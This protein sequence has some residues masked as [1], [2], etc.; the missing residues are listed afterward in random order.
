M[1][2]VPQAGFERALRRAG[3][4][5]RGGNL[6][7]V[8]WSTATD[9]EM[10]GNV[11]WAGESMGIFVVDWT[12]SRTVEL[13]ALARKDVIVCSA[14]LD[15]DGAQTEFTIGERRFAAKSSDMTVVFVPHHESFR[16]ATSV[17]R[18]LKA[19]TVVVDV[20]SVMKAHG[21]PASG[22]PKWLLR[23]IQA[24]RI[25][26]ETLP[27]RH[28]GAVAR[29]VA[30]RRAMYP[31]LATLYYEGKTFELVSAL[32]G[33]L[34][35]H[36]AVQAGDGGFDPR[37]G[38]RLA[39]VKQVIDQAPHRILDVDALACIAAMN[40]TKLRSAFKQVYGMTL[41]GYRTDL[42]LQRADTALKQAGAS[43]KQAARHAGYATTSSFI[44]AYKRR[45]GVCPGAVPAD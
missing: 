24:R 33:E 27:P 38:D 41:S 32:L 16:F 17:S 14:V 36:D 31:S 28:F 22:L 19:V 12:D 3:M 5:V 42:M 6:I 45:Y 8:P 40:R 26:M 20:M 7:E 37:V 4:Q 10:A 25:A 23:T 43:V 34:S 29:D 35:R 39:V 11:A 9:V 21:L 18:G 30:A 13:E 15:W 2:M 44:V 1:K